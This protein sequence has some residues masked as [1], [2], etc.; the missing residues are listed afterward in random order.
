MH[1]HIVDVLIEERAT[2]LMS[3]PFL[4]RQVKRLFYPVLGYRHAV[5]T[6]DTVA[7]MDALSTFKHL[8]RRLELKVTAEGTEHIPAQ[9]GAIVA[10]N[11]PAGIA[12]GVAMFDV[13]R[14]VRQDITFFANRD[15]LRAAPNLAEMLIPVEWVD[16][17]RN[18]AR[19]RETVTHMVRAFRAG[20]IIV[21]F[22][23]GRLA[24]PTVRGLQEREWTTTVANLAQRYGVPVLPAHIRA[25][26]SWLY[27]LLYVLNDELKDMTLFRELLN[28]EGQ[29]YR[30]R[31][32]APMSAQGDVAEATAAIRR[33]VLEDLA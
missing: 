20:R 9:G 16:E 5:H 29:P 19:N 13:L 14:Q 15:A 31:V 1:K 18:H 28:K 21:M 30:I 10:A 33:R 25:R 3:R 4:W 26:N 11:H 6:I 23:S 2:Q 27:Y 17:K 8:S 7:P 22:P 12:D 32:G 24:R